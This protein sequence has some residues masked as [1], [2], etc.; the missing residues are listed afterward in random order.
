[1]DNWK[2]DDQ[3][4]DAYQLTLQFD[5]DESR[6][7]VQKYSNHPGAI[8]L[9]HLNDAIQLFLT[10]DE[11]EYELFK[12]NTDDRVDL[13]SKSSDSPYK[14]YYLSEIK[15]HQTFLQLKFGEELSAAWSFRQSYR[16]TERNIEAYP[17]FFLNDKTR[18]IQQIIVGS[19]PERHQWLLRLLGFEGSIEEG[20]RKLEHFSGNAEFRKLENDITM[21]FI[22]SHMLQNSKKSLEILTGYHDIAISNR[23]INFATVSVLTKFSMNEEAF[24]LLSAFHSDGNSFP[25]PYTS[26]MEGN[27]L[28]QRGNYLEAVLKFEHFINKYTGLNYV[29]DACYKTGIAYILNDQPREA[30]TWFEKAKAIKVSVTEA[31]KYATHALNSVLPDN[32]LIQIRLFTDGGYYEKSAEIL[33]NIDRSQLNNPRDQIEIEYRNARLFHKTDRIDEAISHYKKTIELTFTDQWYFAPNS[34][35]QLGYIYLDKNQ[36]DEAEEYFK[37]CLNYNNHPYQNSIDNKAKAG[38]SRI[39]SLK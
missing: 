6:A 33:G 1:M 8:F 29:K 10:E 12:Q 26:Y 28:L 3:L 37:K 21:A 5:F 17:E 11:H 20:L 7:I 32:R 9:A 30:A 18:G 25:F 2:F 13:I 38:L 31:D 35:L 4:A 22:Y 27:L 19:A 14:R 24:Q 36:L 34:A 16:T 15:L 23:L 39:K